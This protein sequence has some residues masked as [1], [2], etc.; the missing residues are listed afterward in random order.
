M[1]EKQK[2]KIE[3]LVGEMA[4]DFS[5][6]GVGLDKASELTEKWARKEEQTMDAAEA[7]AELGRVE[8]PAELLN[9]VARLANVADVE[10]DV[11]LEAGGGWANAQ[12]RFPDGTTVPFGWFLYTK[13]AG[14]IEAC[15]FGEI[16]KNGYAVVPYSPGEAA[17]GTFG[18]SPEMEVAWR[19]AKANDA[20]G[21]LDDFSSVEDMLVS[22]VAER[23]WSESEVVEAFERAG[24][25]V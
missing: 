5:T 11:T 9:V 22:V 12:V 6:L 25:G 21:D 18:L 20:D 16:M 13:P 2:E 3:R 4:Q 17:C 1:T 15:V 19:R 8:T 7:K 23:R 14:E 10:Y 24:W